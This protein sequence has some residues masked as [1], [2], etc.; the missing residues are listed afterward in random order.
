[1]K[2]TN[3]QVHIEELVLHGFPPGDRHVIAAAV[4][5]ELATM[6]E[7]RDLPPSIFHSGEI[8]RVEGGA[9]TIAPRGKAARVGHQ[10]AQAVYGGLSK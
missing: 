3:V 10:I 6:F 8:A 7:Q 2:S 4:Q 9:F 1:M 5:R